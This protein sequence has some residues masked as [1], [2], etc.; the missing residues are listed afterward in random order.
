MA[1][2][3]LS[4]ENARDRGYAADLIASGEVVV[5][6]FN[7]I[8]TLLGDADDPAVADKAAEAKQRPQ[9]K[10]VALVCPPEFFGE[11]VVTDA[12]MLL[13]AQTL[14]RSLH[15][16][17]VILPA[18]RAAPAHVVQQAT[19]LNVWTE[20]QPLRELVLELR[21]RGRRSLAGTSANRTGEPTITDVREVTAT[22]GAHVPAIVVDNVDSVPPERRHSASIIDLT[23][24]RPRLVREGSVPADELSTAVRSVGLGEL[25]VEPNVRRV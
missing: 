8:F 6:A 1:A 22:F 25:V 18:S 19:I 20:H 9:A 3:I 4:L 15:A 7:G 16:L 24:A 23:G 12:T 17:G 21:R 11:H 10:G 2:R 13:R 14:Q 5:C